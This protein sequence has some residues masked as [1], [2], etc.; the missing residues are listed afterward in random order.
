MNYYDNMSCAELSQKTPIPFEYLNFAEIDISFFDLRA[1]INNNLDF[2]K[3]NI[4]KK[5]INYILNS[6]AFIYEKA[7][8]K[9]RKKGQW[10]GKI[11]SDDYEYVSCDFGKFVDKLVLEIGPVLINRILEEILSAENRQNNWMNIP[12]N[13]LNHAKF[14][15][16]HNRTIYIGLANVII[17]KIGNK[18]NKLAERIKLIKFKNNE[19]NF[20]KLSRKLYYRDNNLDEVNDEYY[21]QN[22]SEIRCELIKNN[23]C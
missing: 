10:G 3:L 23:V 22:Y 7:K 15:L 2:A 13:K 18:N 8:N 16:L 21:K 9:L 12:E 20:A 11:L 4:T 19:K 14:C 17:N 5:I 6:G 1:L